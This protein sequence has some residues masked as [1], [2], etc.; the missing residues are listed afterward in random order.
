MRAVVGCAFVSVLLVWAMR[1]E[2][3]PAP[4]LGETASCEEQC[5]LER[6]RDD[7]TCDEGV[8]SEGDRSLCHVA[9]QARL[10][11]CLRICED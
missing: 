10:E 1:A 4:K 2:A 5:Q 8:L 6:A 7:A 3:V 11:V 9:V